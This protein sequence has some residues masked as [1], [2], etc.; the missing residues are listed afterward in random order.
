ME[1]IL[2]FEYLQDSH[3]HFPCFVNKREI[4]YFIFNVILMKSIIPD[5]KAVSGKYNLSQ[6]AL[7]IP[8]MEQ[9]KGSM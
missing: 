9:L 6:T 5:L 2:K 1:K 4:I 3:K 8:T 7:E